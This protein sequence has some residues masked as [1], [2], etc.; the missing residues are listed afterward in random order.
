MDSSIDRRKMP[1]TRSL[2]DHDLLE[3]NRSCRPLRLCDLLNEL[4]LLL[5]GGCGLV[6]GAP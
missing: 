4:I 2:H 6:V 5:V 1:Q 3:R